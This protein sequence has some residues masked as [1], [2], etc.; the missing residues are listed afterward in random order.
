MGLPAQ[1]CVL[2]QGKERERAAYFLRLGVHRF[3]EL[4]MG[5]VV[6]RFVPLAFIAFFLGRTSTPEE[7]KEEEADEE[8]EEVVTSL[9]DVEPLVPLDESDCDSAELESSSGFHSQSER[10]SKASR[11]DVASLSVDCESLTPTQGAT[12][13]SVDCKS[14]T[15]TQGATQQSVDCKSLTPTQGATQQ[16]VDWIIGPLS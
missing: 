1:T 12:Q 3:L 16:S 14:L 5:V 13:Q 7:E 8:E 10:P 4:S 2:L 11:Y 6:G 9:D 15:P